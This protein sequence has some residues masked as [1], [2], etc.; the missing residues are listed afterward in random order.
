MTDNGDRNLLPVAS[1]ICRDRRDACG[2]VIDA[3]LGRIEDHLAHLHTVFDQRVQLAEK[4]LE[5]QA[6]EYER[7]LQA[8]NHAHEQ[9]V[10]DRE[11]TLPRETFASF[12]REFD[13]FRR[14]VEK[15]LAAAEAR[16]ATWMIIMGIAFA[17]ISVALRFWK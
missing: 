13:L 16:S 11:E 8:L 12:E 1:D 17:V 6:K 15:N 7:R 5:I 2:K 14:S 3:R 9:A 4:A 10:K